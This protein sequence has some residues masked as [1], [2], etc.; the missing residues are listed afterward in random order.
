MSVLLSI[1]WKYGRDVPEEIRF[2]AAHCRRLVAVL[3]VEE[4]AAF[5]ERVNLDAVSAQDSIQYIHILGHMAHLL[6]AFRLIEVVLL[7]A[8][9]HESAEVFK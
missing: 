7:N 6:L 8:G 4:I 2:R 3:L 9:F 5:V 1:S